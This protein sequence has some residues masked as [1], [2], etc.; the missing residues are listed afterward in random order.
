MYRFEAQKDER[1]KITIAQLTIK[2]RNCKTKISK[3]TDRLECTGNTTATVRLFEIPWADVAGVPKDC[4]CSVDKDKLMPFTYV[5]T[6]SVVELR[7]DVTGM[8]A[9]DDFNTLSFEGSWKIVKTPLCSR[10]L[11]MRGPSGELLFNYPHESSEDVSEVIIKAEVLLLLPSSQVFCLLFNCLSVREAKTTNFP[12]YLN[13]I[14][15]H[16]NTWQ[17]ILIKTSVS[18]LFSTSVA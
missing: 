6:S 3:D 16:S 11:R 2:N 4:L 8:N 13:L 14:L 15:L 18:S 10:D 7:F 17:P 5:S 9:S 1:I 12:I